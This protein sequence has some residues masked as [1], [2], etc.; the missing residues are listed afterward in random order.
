MPA[1][2]RRDLIRRLKVKSLH[3]QHPKIPYSTIY[4]HCGSCQIRLALNI[5]AQEILHSINLYTSSRKAYF[6]DS[7]T[8]E[9]SKC[10]QQHN[11]ENR[12]DQRG[13]SRFKR[14]GWTLES[15]S[16]TT[17]TDNSHK[18]QS[19]TTVTDKSHRQQSQ[20]TVTT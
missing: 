6:L 2:G 8:R 7:T 14:A 17:V 16:Q 9:Q 11:M 13:L 1:N 19:Q 3:Y 12:L 10:R 15:E 20:T 18:Q 5:F 4:M